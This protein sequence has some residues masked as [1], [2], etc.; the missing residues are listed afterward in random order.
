[1]D[2]GRGASFGAR[3]CLPILVRFWCLGS[4]VAFFALGAHCVQCAQ[5]P[6][7][8]CMVQPSRWALCSPFLHPSLYG[9]LFALSGLKYLHSQALSLFPLSN[10]ALRKVRTI[11]SHQSVNN[12]HDKKCCPLWERGD[13]HPMILR[14]QEEW[15]FAFASGWKAF[16]TYSHSRGRA[17]KSA[18]QDFP[19]KGLLLAFSLCL[20]PTFTCYS[21]WCAV[22]LHPH[23]FVDF[24]RTDSMFHSP[25]P[26]ALA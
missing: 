19:K 18:S 3:P 7:P 5:L 1:M 12:H 22:H 9:I 17:P 25:A 10:T 13:C 23:K 20:K 11:H 26:Q 4:S 21:V 6:C 8:S 2:Q 16:L 15:L 14:N 24:L